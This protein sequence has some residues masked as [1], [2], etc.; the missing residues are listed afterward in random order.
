MD[1]PLYLRMYERVI[2]DIEQVGST[3]SICEE[4]RRELPFMAARAGLEAILDEIDAV[5]NDDKAVFERFVIWAYCKEK[6]YDEI[7][8][9]ALFQLNDNYRMHG[10]A[11]AMQGIE[12]PSETRDKLNTEFGDKPFLAASN[13]LADDLK[14]RHRMIKLHSEEIVPIVTGFM[15]LWDSS[16]N[17]KS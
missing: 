2:K 12:I 17:T 8:T 13:R 16:E 7:T 5:S 9:Y 14:F 6:C 1:I 10:R 15:A 11:D 3:E 4:V